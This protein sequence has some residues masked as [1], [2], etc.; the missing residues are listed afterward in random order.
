MAKTKMTKSQAMEMFKNVI[1]KNEVSEKIQ[2]EYDFLVDEFESNPANVTKEDITTFLNR[3]T[4]EGYINEKVVDKESEK[5]KEVKKEEVKKEEVK[6]EEKPQIKNEGED[7]EMARAVLNPV[8]PVV[9]PTTKKKGKKKAENSTKKIAKKETLLTMTHVEEG[10]KFKP[11]PKTMKTELGNLKLR[12]DINSLDEMAEAFAEGTP[13]MLANVWVKDMLSIYDYDPMGLLEN[14]E[15]ELTEFPNDLDLLQPTFCNEKVM[16]GVSLYTDVHTTYL[17]DGFEQ[18]D[19]GLRNNGFVNYQ[20]YE[21][22][23]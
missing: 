11:F 8:I 4:K 13:L 12:T 3:L 9:A 2:A 16:Y 10:Y 15:E 23:Q 17:A 1:S 21:I 20:V 22:V 5:I 19:N 6:E 14:E 18:D 7:E